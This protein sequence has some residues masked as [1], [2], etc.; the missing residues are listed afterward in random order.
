VSNELIA[1]RPLLDTNNLRQTDDDA[2]ID[3]ATSI[4]IGRLLLGVAG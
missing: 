4:I 2:G 3:P 1:R